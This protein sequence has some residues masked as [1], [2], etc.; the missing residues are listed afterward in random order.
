MLPEY[1]HEELLEKLESYKIE[2]SMINEEMLRIQ[3]EYKASSEKWFT[4]FEL[5]PIG[6]LEVADNGVI[7]A[8]NLSKC[9]MLGVSRSEL[10]HKSIIMYIHLDDRIIYY[11]YFKHAN[12]QICQLRLK[13]KDDTYIWVQVSGSKMEGDVYFLNITDISEIHASLDKLKDI[14]AIAE[15]R[16]E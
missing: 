4:M 6:Y 1:K 8:S 9:T 12:T 3:N 13:R 2:L 14:I 10:L 5:A 11:N 7:Q 16:N 15:A